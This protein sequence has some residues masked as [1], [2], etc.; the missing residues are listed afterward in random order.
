ML[1]LIEITL[2]VF[3]LA[4]I[5][6][7]AVAIGFIAKNAR[8]NSS[9]LAVERLEKEMLTCHAEIL[10]LQKELTVREGQQSRAPIVPIR[11][12]NI[13]PAKDGLADNGL[14]KKLRN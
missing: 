3:T 9:K 14:R 4:A 5:V 11:D 13:E 10:R 8:I 1:A 7:V 6:I 12:N 2:N